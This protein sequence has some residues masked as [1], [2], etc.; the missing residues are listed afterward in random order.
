MLVDCAGVGRRV[1]GGKGEMSM[2]DYSGWQEVACDVA[3]STRGAQ[4]VIPGSTLTDLD[5]HYGKPVMFTEWWNDDER[6]ILRDYYWHPHSDAG[7][8]VHY[9][10][11]GNA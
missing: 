7:K 3:D 8:C 5:G 6:P 11:E 10:P 1:D 2:H 4:H 9:V